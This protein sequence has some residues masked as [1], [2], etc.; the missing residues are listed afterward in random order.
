MQTNPMNIPRISSIFLAVLASAGLYATTTGHGRSALAQGEDQYL[1]HMEISAKRSGADFVPDGNLSRQIWKNA[2][3]TEFDHDT[4]GKIEHP[5]LRTRVAAAWTDRYLYFAFSVRYDSLNTYKGE[6]IAKE[7]WELWNRDVVEVFLNPEPHRMTHYYEFEV[8]PNNQ[9]IDLEIEKK[10]TP[11]NDAS[12]NSGFEHATRIN[13]KRRVWVT[14]MRIPLSALG[15][16][17]I[18]KGDLWRV[19]FF[20]AAGAGGDDQRVFLAWSP[21]PQGGTFHVPNRF[22]ILRFVK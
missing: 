14:E 15:I 20:R 4:A 12:W 22:G 13:E 16:Q 2:E 9:W 10:K 7:R 8:A 19:N 3:W 21:I 5:K 6:D 18:H 1:S 17:E 11:F